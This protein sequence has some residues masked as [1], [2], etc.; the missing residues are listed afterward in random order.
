[1]GIMGAF[2]CIGYNWVGNSYA[3]NTALLR[4]EWGYKGYIVSDLGAIRNARGGFYSWVTCLISGEDS[5][6]ETINWTRDYVKEVLSYY[7]RGGVYSNIILN[8]V[9]TNT[10]HILTAWS[11]SNGYIANVKEAIA[12]TRAGGYNFDPATPDEHGYTDIGWYGL[13][14]IGEGKVNDGKA[15][16]P[17]VISGNNGLSEAKFIIKSKVPLLEVSG[18]DGSSFEFENST[19]KSDSL[20]VYTL[21]FRAKEVKIADGELFSLVMNGKAPLNARDCSL[22]I[23][24]ENALDRIG[25]STKLYIGERPVPP[26]PSGRNLQL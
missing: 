19:G 2:N 17:V 12:K 8:S 24:Y 7:E 20:N 26:P 13:I 18:S 9:R 4:D 1:M 14:T 10:R 21:N 15:R 3:L 5:L 11:R 23:I 16:F 6:E 25:H 22:S